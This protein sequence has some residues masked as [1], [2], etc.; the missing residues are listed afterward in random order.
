MAIFCQNPN[1]K[2]SG[3]L[4]PIYARIVKGPNIFPIMTIPTGQF[5]D[6][7]T[8]KY[9]RFKV[10]VKFCSALSLY[11]SLK[12]LNES[13]RGCFFSGYHALLSKNINFVGLTAPTEYNSI[14]VSGFWFS[15]SNIKVTETAVTATIPA[16]D[17][18]TEV[19]TGASQVRFICAVVYSDPVEAEKDP[20]FQV[21]G[22]EKV[23][24][25]F[26]FAASYS[27]SK[28]LSP[29]QLNL[30]TRYQRKTVYL[31]SVI[32]SETGLVLQNSQSASA[33]I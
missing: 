22:V 32:E 9:P 11:P 2:I 27:F 33:V 19:P 26:N 31:L 6:A 15:V 29:Y 23:V 28:N 1:R 25:S 14:A 18:K 5:Y 20:P 24:A 12:A 17:T 21:T 7:F 16:L 8:Y 10:A 30:G 4:G 3:R 13:L